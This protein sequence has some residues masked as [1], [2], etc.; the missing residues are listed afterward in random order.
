MKK[1]LLLA[2]PGLFF[3]MLAF[4]Q[5]AIHS[6]DTY[7]NLQKEKEWKQDY[8]IYRSENNKYALM[9]YNNAEDKSRSKY[10]LQSSQDL[11]L[12]KIPKG[13]FYSPNLKIYRLS[14]DKY[15]FFPARY[16]KD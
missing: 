4:G 11:Q 9:D 16:I 2:V 10:N 12:H 1:I 5:P 15:G 14:K 13:T 8:R 7:D 3:S 6:S